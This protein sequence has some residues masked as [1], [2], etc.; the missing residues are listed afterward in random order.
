MEVSRPV[1]RE[2]AFEPAPGLASPH[3]Q[4][5]LA[6][7]RL[8]R[9][10]LRLKPSGLR[11]AALG[12]L[13]TTRDGT[14][15]EAW[16]SH[17]SGEP[18]GTVLMFPGW[19]GH[20]DSI[21]MLTIGSRLYRAGWDVVRLNFR[22]HGDTHHLNEGLFHSCLLEEMVDGVAECAALARARPLIVGGC[23]L[24]GNF[25]LR[26]ALRRD[27]D[28]LPVGGAFAVA[29]VINAHHTMESME[30]TLGVYER[31][32]IRKWL[33]SLGRKQRL[34]PHRYDLAPALRM[35]RVRDVTDWLIAQGYIDMPSLDEYLRA[36]SLDDAA[37]TGLDVPAHVLVSRDDPI[38]PIEDVEHL[39][40]SPAM[41]VEIAEHGGHCG[42]VD[43]YTLRS[44]VEWRIARVLAEPPFSRPP[45]P[46][47]E[48][49][50]RG[51]ANA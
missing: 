4:S 42:F 43:R 44:W 17:Q 27:E 40:A 6:S 36:Y 50:A 12:R 46:V 35:R 18:R 25:A 51:A 1:F 13:I 31:Y 24:G 38:I 47:A 28:R 30:R 2:A 19:E 33:G 34:F 23:S 21:Y 8:R 48:T 45:Q 20:Q 26:V 3:V 10:G 16:F 39:Q 5:I 49:A 15:L 29:P 32:F 22:D 9:W 11:R 7:M 37:L 14:R 41:T